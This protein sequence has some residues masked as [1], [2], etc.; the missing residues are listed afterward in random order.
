VR[1]AFDPRMRLRKLGA[2]SGSGS[3]QGVA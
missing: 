1:D 3:A 2:L